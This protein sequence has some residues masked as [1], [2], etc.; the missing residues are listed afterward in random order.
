VKRYAFLIGVS[1]PL[2]ISCEQNSTNQPVAPGAAALNAFANSEWSEPI[3]LPAPINSSSTELGA[4]LSPDGLSIYVGS[5]RAGGH[6]NVDIWAV[7]RECVDCPWG[8]AVNLN[9][10][11]SQSDGSAA[12]SPD[13]HL[14]FFSSNRDGGHGGDDIW[15]SYRDDTSDDQG[16]Q[17]PVNLG[18][19]VNTNGHET[20]PVYV[21]ALNAEGAN[22]YFARGPV[23]GNSD[24][25]KA[26]VKLD[27]ETLGDAVPVA[28][29]NSTA[30]EA[31]PAISHDGKE[32]FFHSARTA[33]GFGLTDIWVATRKSPN[34]S[35]SEP[36]NLGSNINTLAG[37][38]TPGLS[39]DGRTLLW[40]AAAAARTSLGRQDVWMVTRRPGRGD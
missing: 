31:E 4:Q 11:S 20:G 10:N 6:G 30:A 27:G 35:W 17:T 28:E 26:L 21:P 8:E 40:S 38:L 14:L 15:I 2:L 3:H 34:E 23:T 36:V 25:Y 22:I 33:G 24:I 29:L 18:A 32:I 16:W 12:F 1:V 19:G 39:F 13:G 7:R 9:I 37:D 5:E